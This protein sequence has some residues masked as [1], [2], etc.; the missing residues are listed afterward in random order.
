M[1]LEVATAAL[2]A[3]RAELARLTRPSALWHGDTPVIP[4]APFRRLRPA[5]RRRILAAL[6][7][8]LTQR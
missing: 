7:R 3:Y 6:R 1:R 8:A 2:E 5:A 4:L